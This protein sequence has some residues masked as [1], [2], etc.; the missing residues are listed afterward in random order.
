MAGQQITKRKQLTLFPYP[1]NPM[2]EWS[3][4]EREREKAFTPLCIYMPLCL[5][6][7]LNFRALIGIADRKGETRTHSETETNRKIN[8]TEKWGEMW[9]NG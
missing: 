2:E 9:M 4:R 7:V 6:F 5:G 3:E 8:E 1:I